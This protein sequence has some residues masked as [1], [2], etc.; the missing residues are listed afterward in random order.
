MKAFFEEYG[1]AIVIVV[2]VGVLIGVAVVSSDKGKTKMN[3]TYDKFNEQSDK[4][5]DKAFS[6]SDTDSGDTNQ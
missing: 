4:V 1:L 5:I 6:N 2:V 3:D